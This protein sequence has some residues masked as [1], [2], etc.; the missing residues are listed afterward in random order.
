MNRRTHDRSAEIAAI[1]MTKPCGPADICEAMG[2]SR[3]ATDN[4]KTVIN[5]FKA[6]GLIY[7]CGFN[8]YGWPIYAWQPKP[9]ALPD[10]VSERPRKAP[11]S[12]KAKRVRA[13]SSVFALGAQ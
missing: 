12:A 4:V 8:G 6:R 1:I 10:A 7:V 9:H 5:A 3:H 2:M 13:V 11:E